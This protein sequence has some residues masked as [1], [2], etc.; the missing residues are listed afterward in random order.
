[1]NNGSEVEIIP[2]RA[3]LGAE[4]RG[5]NLSKPLSDA[6]F[7]RIETAVYDHIAVFFRNQKMDDAKLVAL[8]SRFG[9]LH[10]APLE[11]YGENAKE[12]P[13]EVELI[14]NILRDGKPIGALASG[15]ASWHTDMSMYDIP[16]SITLLYA[17]EI[18]P[19]GGDTRFTNLRRAYEMLPPDLHDSVEGRISI[20]D[21]A[22]TATGEV[23][24]GF[25]EV[26]DKT[27]MPGARHPIVRC[28]PVTGR[29]ALF[30]GRMGHG[31]IVGLPV[32]ESDVLL[33]RLWEHMTQAKFVWEHQWQVG[34]VL[35]WD[36]R[37]CAH[38]RGAF[39]PNSRRL[40]RR[41]TAISEKP[42]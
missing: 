20:H 25:S 16:S 19:S 3:A 7:R 13:P 12:L 22:Y 40:L 14:S 35:L 36:N 33:S 5:V 37:Q 1:M 24:P 28:H 9:E 39:D 4:I 42:F 30:L 17:E 15:E 26:V 41:V 2:T 18:P 34:D 31:Y 38:S 29:K 21:I 27:K 11:Q 10:K 32:P 23:R 8:G 6:A